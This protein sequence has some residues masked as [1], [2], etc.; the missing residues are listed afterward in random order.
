VVGFGGMTGAVGGML[1][2]KVT[3]EI[4]QTT[5]SYVPV[6]IVAASAYLAALLVI[7]L[8]VPRLDPARLGR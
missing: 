6:F 7:H 1:I 2:A 5:G 8:L 4:L 3:A